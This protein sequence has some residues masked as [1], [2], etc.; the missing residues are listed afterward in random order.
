MVPAVIKWGKE[1]FTG[2]YVRPG[3]LAEELKQEIF[4]LTH[5]PIERQK[6]MCSGAW[7]GMLPDGARIDKALALRSGQSELTIMLMGTA[8]A[9]PVAPSK[10]TVF[11]EDLSVE[12]G[13]K[14]DAAAAAQAIATA[15]GMIAA[16]QLEPGP[17]RNESKAIMASLPIKYNHFVH[18]LPQQKIEDALR[19]QRE[20]GTLLYVCAMTLGHEVGKAYV[21]AIACLADGTLASGLDNGRIQLWR[22][23]QRLCEVVHEPVGMFGGRAGAIACLSPLPSNQHE[24]AFASGAEGSMKLWTADGDCA[25]TISAP[26]G[27]L[28]ACLAAL[29]GGVAIA[30]TFHQAQPFD[31][32]AFRLVPQGEEQRRRRAEAQAAQAV[33]QAAFEHIARRVTIVE[34]VQPAHDSGVAGGSGGGATIRVEVL[35]P[36]ES[37]TA[38]IMALAS[39]GE[40]CDVEIVSGDAGGGLHLWSRASSGG[41]DGTGGGSSNGGSDGGL[42]WRRGGVLQLCLESSGD[43]GSSI[44]CLEPISQPGVCAAALAQFTGAPSGEASSTSPPAGAVLLSVPPSVNG[45]VVLVDVDRRA[46]V[47]ALYAHT[48][49]VRCMCA[50]PD[51]G[52]ATGGGKHDGIVRVWGRS[53]WQ[54]TPTDKSGYVPVLRDAMQTL[55]EPGYCF[56]LA[57][58]PDAKPGS[59]LFAL[60]CARYN[61]VK[62]CL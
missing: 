10:P 22:H 16:L 14:R 50:M 19:R 34:L 35:E 12:E 59:Q 5:V 38:P 42:Q 61:T 7:K 8:D 27:C 9:V 26:P 3:M 54:S 52:L 33:Q 37:A 1:R 23:G 32:N 46:V 24:L 15:E 18:G 4:A 44:I 25:A 21:N 56:G 55:R 11:R 6:I 20:S 49:M 28:P 13:T 53:Q 60:A 43:H 17:E 39:M 36:T 31:Q 29:P 58:L 41:T 2:V 62:I 48:G 30:V 45:G 40:A 51:G 47:A 57:I